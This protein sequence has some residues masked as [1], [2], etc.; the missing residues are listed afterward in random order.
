MEAE[1]IVQQYLISSNIPFKRNTKFKKNRNTIAEL[2]FIIPNAVIE[3]KSGFFRMQYPKTIDELLKQILRLRS[4]MPPDFTLYLFSI[5]KITDDIMKLILLTDPYIKVIYNLN[6]IVYH[7]LEYFTMDTGVIRS[8]VSHNN[9]EYDNQ[10]KRYNPLYMPKSIYYRALAGFTNDLCERLNK[11]HIEFTEIIPTT[12][13]YL[14]G[15]NLHDI[16][17]N[18]IFTRFYEKIKYCELK[19]NDLL[20]ITGITHCCVKCN[21]IKYIECFLTSS[22]YLNYELNTCTNCLGY[23][24]KGSY[25][26]KIQV[27]NNLLPLNSIKRMK[28]TV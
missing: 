25:K 16:I 1:N 28:I 23:N 7:P 26:R 5:H 6:E 13:I 18:T 8:I 11:L 9:I 22:D 20:L 14:T 21:K 17:N 3:V 24:N 2:D 10:I 12:C 15:R 27:D 19:W 4:F